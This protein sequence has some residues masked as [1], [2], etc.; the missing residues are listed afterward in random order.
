M[1]LQAVILV[2]AALS[3]SCGSDR[4]PAAAP[5]PAQV[6]DPDRYQAPPELRAQ[7]ELMA[8]LFPE[9][10]G[11]LRRRASKSTTESGE[12]QIARLQSTYL[13]SGGRW[14]LANVTFCG[15]DPDMAACRKRWRKE[16]TELPVPDGEGSHN[17]DSWKPVAGTSS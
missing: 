1:K 4:T 3:L 16:V 6:I 14:L 2:T 7:V 11:D 10:I 15:K 13:A 9:F 12:R 5:P 8:A 17:P